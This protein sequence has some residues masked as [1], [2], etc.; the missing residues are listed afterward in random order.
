MRTFTVGLWLILLLLASDTQAASK[1][2]VAGLVTAL[3]GGVMMIVGLEEEC[4][5][6]YSTHTFQ[7]LPT[8]CVFISRSGSDVREAGLRISRP[9]AF[10]G[11]IGVATAGI[12]MML[13]PEQARVDIAFS[14]HELRVSK[15][16]G[17]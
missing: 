7:D 17:F 5:S 13:L 10:W 15:T 4:P 16:I 14:P 12:V 6:G 8:Q 2:K 1:K 3:T 11:G 9:G